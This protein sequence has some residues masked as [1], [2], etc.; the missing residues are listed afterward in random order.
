[1]RRLA[2]VG[3]PSE[4]EVESLDALRAWV[5]TLPTAGARWLESLADVPLE[6]IDVLWVRN[7][8]EPGPGVLAWL[9]AGGRLLATHTAVRL[10]SPLGLEPHPPIPAGAT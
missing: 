9:R 8:V 2:V 5:G 4:R 6:Q 1:M 10:V 7:E 3:A